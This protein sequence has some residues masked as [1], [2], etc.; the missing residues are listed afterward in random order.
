MGCMIA[1]IGGLFAWC[2]LVLA[3]W[4][5]GSAY[6]EDYETAR[7]VLPWAFIVGLVGISL[8][9]VGIR[10]AFSS[11]SKDKSSHDRSNSTPTEYVFCPDCGCLAVD[12]SRT[13]EHCGADLG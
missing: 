7:T 12:G 8:V 10:S 6:S 9:A 13:C 11:D 2:G 3:V 5:Y 1:I 4:G